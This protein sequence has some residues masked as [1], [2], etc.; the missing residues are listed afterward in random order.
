[1]S[2]VFF[3]FVQRALLDL[4]KLLKN[5]ALRRAFFCFI[6]FVMVLLCKKWLFFWGISKK[7]VVI[8]KNIVIFT[9]EQKSALE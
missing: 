4:G 1:M 8:P 2:T 5:N 9:A 3:F 7:M 6:F